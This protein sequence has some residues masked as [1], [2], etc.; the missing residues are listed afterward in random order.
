MGTIQN[1]TKDKHR[2]REREPTKYD[3]KYWN[4]IFLSLANMGEGGE[5]RLWPLSV[6]IKSKIG[7]N[8]NVASGT[9]KFFRKLP[10]INLCFFILSGT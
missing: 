5:T 3:L 7:L 10:L 6:Y 4:S 1:G 8:S 9:Y 2:D